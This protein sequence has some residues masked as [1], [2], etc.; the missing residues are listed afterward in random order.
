MI[1]LFW[2][3]IIGIVMVGLAFVG[4]L[5]AHLFWHVKPSRLDSFNDLMSEIGHGR[6]TLIYF[7]SNF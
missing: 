3:K 7:Y 2:L 5:T 4:W 6:P 1:D